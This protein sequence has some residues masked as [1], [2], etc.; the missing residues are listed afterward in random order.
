MLVLWRTPCDVRIPL[1]LGGQS[2]ALDKGMLFGVHNKEYLSEGSIKE[3]MVDIC[4]S[5]RDISRQT[6]RY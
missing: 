2:S 3:G 6:A 4:V 1:Q 5:L